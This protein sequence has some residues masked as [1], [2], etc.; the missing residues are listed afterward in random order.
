LVDLSRAGN[1]VIVVEHDEEIMRCADH[2]IDM[3]PGAGVDGGMV[4]A[5]GKPE[6]VEQ[7]KSLTALWLRGERR[8]DIP[9]RRRAPGNW[10]VLHGACENNLRGDTVRFPLGVLCGVCGVS[11]SG[12]STLVID[13][14]GR[15]LAP[16]KYSTSVAY[17]PLD[18]GAYT[19]LEGEPARTYIVD[20]SRAGMS[21]PAAWLGVSDLIRDLFLDS[22][23]A[24][25]LGVSSDRPPVCPACGGRGSQRIDM[26]FL[27][28]LDER[29]ED[30]AGTGWTKEAE[31][32]RYRGV[33]LRDVMRLQLAPALDLFRGEASIARPLQA[34]VDV[35]LGYLALKQ[36][37]NSLSGGEA[38]RLKI[39]QEIA[40]RRT[41]GTLYILDEPTV[42]QH[43]EDVL[44]L[45]GVLHR[46]VD[47]GASVLVV[48]HHPLLLT[49]CDWLIE[50]GPGGGPDGGA[51]I[52]SGTPESAAH[53]STPIAPYLAHILKERI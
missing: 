10:L 52:F 17:E 34:A 3:G 18:P 14:L 7:G 46:L 4:V 44:R 15:I 32:I 2:L 19:S 16:T 5:Q 21:S 22:G 26:A 47:C 8:I 51:V 35:G 48:E 9:A 53:G 20:Q 31:T 24:R 39:A 27:P 13:T 50:L 41:A 23:E 1:T 37:G 30:C 49:A 29:C 25:E 40:K 28:D 33:A 42:G 12:K 38:Q 43:M 11:G 6:Q 45:S 36:P